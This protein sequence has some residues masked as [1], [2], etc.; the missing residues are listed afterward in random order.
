MSV[1]HHLTTLR[2]IFAE[3][4]DPR[5]AHLVSRP[6][7]E[8]MATDASVVRELLIRHLRRPDALTRQHWP[9]LGLDI[10]QTPAFTLV[11]N[12]W[13]PHPEGRTDVTTKAIHHHGPML[14]STVTAF[15]P[16]YEHWT[17]HH[18]RRD[19][20]AHRYE[21]RPI[22][23]GSH[24][25]GHV[26]FVD[27]GVAHVPMFPASLSITYALWSTSTA[28]RAIDRVKRW[29]VFR[30]RE[31]YYR[32]LAQRFGL[33]KAL[34]LKTTDLVDFLPTPEG[35]VGTPRVEPP[36]GPRAH[37]LQSLFHVLQAT[38]NSDLGR[39]IDPAAL[40]FEDRDRLTVWAGLRKLRR[41]EPIPAVLSDGHWN[42]P[43]ANV[44]RAQIASAL[45]VQAHAA[46]APRW[47]VK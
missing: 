22:Q 9:S 26:A 35:F 1:D 25:Q 28:P 17:F 6:V 7:L 45:S 14:L 19:D 2:A 24:P 12:C 46:G 21:L 36:F 47:V 38:G 15:G 39:T 8:T 18:R 30:G 40:P 11:A 20:A 5:S 13:L 33:S 31:A 37:Y 42:R 27:A 4:H 32:S 41:E 3:S 16:G 10:A 44:T 23:V 29:P 43:E 34:G